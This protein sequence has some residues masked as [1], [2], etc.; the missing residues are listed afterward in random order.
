ME[1]REQDT[2]T[3]E[4]EARRRCE[5]DRATERQCA[6][7]FSLGDRRGGAEVRGRTVGRFQWGRGRVTRGAGSD[8]W[9][10]GTEDRGRRRR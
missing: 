6:A 2:R 10:S 4:E 1:V 9:E 8:G 7:S 5:S 3:A